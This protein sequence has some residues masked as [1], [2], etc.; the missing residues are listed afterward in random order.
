MNPPILFVLT[1]A[2]AIGSG[3]IAGLFCSFSNFVMKALASLP[4][5]K[6]ASA[7]QAIN[8][9]ILNPWFLSVFVGTAL[10]SLSIMVLAALHWSSPGAGWIIAGGLLYF[11]GGFMVTIVFNVPMNDALAAIDPTTTE[12]AAVWGDYLRRWTAWNHVRSITTLSA[13][14]LLIY[15]LCRLRTIA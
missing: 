8:A 7:M 3:L 9:T 10:A 12:G 11:L 15:G 4:P 1:F 6:G 2:S 5:E 14:A 13:T